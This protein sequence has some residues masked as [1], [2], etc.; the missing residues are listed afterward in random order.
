[1]NWRW[2]SYTPELPVGVSEP[3]MGTAIRREGDITEY[4]L[5]FP[6][7]ILGLK[8]APKPGSA[9][10]IAL[11]ITDAD[12]GKNGRRGLKLFNGITEDKDPQRYGKLWLR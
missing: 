4:V 5:T 3:R 8:Q 7:E 9:L 10:G 2:I 11:A 1:M 6:W 12:P